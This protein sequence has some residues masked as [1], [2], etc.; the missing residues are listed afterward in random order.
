MTTSHTFRITV[1]KYVT[2]TRA[3]IAICEV[4]T[5]AQA[6]AFLNSLN[7]KSKPARRD[8]SLP[9]IVTAHNDFHAEPEFDD[10]MRDY[11]AEASS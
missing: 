1:S 6:Y 11:T 7:N 5:L 8:P 4:D 3:P 2:G 9:L 10:V